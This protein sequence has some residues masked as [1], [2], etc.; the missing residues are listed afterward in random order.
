MGVKY[1]ISDKDFNRKFAT[2]YQLSILTGVD[3]LVFL[4]SDLTNNRAL[5]LRSVAYPEP[6]LPDG[7]TYDGLDKAL[8]RDDLFSLRYGK[9]VIAVGNAAPG[10]LVPDRLYHPE[11]RHSYLDGVRLAD[12]GPAMQ[13][14]ADEVRERKVHYV[15]ELPTE[16]LDL[17]RG[18][19]PAAAISHVATQL[20]KETVPA[21]A[22]TGQYGLLIYLEQG[23]LH[24]LLQEQGELLA[25]NA[26]QVHSANDVLYFTLMLLQQYQVDPASVTARVGGWVLEDAEI[27]RLL[28]RYIS[29]IDFL[30]APSTLHFDAR[31]KEVQHHLFFG[32]Y[33]MCRR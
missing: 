9:I 11:K 17:L 15:Y 22:D 20:L 6:D 30:A 27:F 19:F 2:T 18:H 26:Y 7:K 24:L 25:A 31:F 5:Y 33:A 4:I 13:G 14:L 12:T 23:M 28:S 3:S 29:V 21:L 16:L 8:L 10:V 1:D 32:L